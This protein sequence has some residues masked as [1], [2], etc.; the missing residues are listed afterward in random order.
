MPAFDFYS[1]RSFKIGGQEIGFTRSKKLLHIAGEDWTVKKWLG[2]VD[3][4]WRLLKAEKLVKEPVKEVA[5]WEGKSSTFLG[6]NVMEINSLSRG[7]L[8]KPP[9]WLRPFYDRVVTKDILSGE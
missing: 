8:K 7:V 9:F 4:V 3:R 5:P 2:T 6:Y 1:L